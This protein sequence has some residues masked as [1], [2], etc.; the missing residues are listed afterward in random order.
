MADFKTLL[1][2]RDQE[3]HEEV[4]DSIQATLEYLVRRERNPGENPQE[5][6]RPRRH[7]KKE[8]TAENIREIRNQIG[9][10]NLYGQYS[11]TEAVDKANFHNMAMQPILINTQANTTNTGYYLKDFWK[12]EPREVERSIH[13]FYCR[14]AG[15]AENDGEFKQ[16][17]K[18][19]SLVQ[20]SSP[21]I[22]LNIVRLLENRNDSSAEL[23]I[24][25]LENENDA[26][27]IPPRV[28][29]TDRN[30]PIIWVPTKGAR[31]L[32]SMEEMNMLS[33]S[34]ALDDMISVLTN[35][36][37]IINQY[38]YDKQRIMPVL[39]NIIL[40]SKLNV[41]LTDIREPTTRIEEIIARII[42]QIK[43][44]TTKEKATNKLATYKMG[45]RDS[46][47]TT[48]GNLATLFIQA[49]ELNPETSYNPTSENFSDLLYQFIAESM[50]TLT[51]G[52]VK[53]EIAQRLANR[54]GVKKSQWPD[55]DYL[56]RVVDQHYRET[57]TYP[58][59]F[60]CLNSKH[61]PVSFNNHNNYQ[62]QRKTSELEGGIFEK[63]LTENNASTS[64]L[65][66]TE[67]PELESSYNNWASNITN[68]P[69]LRYDQENNQET[70]DTPE[71]VL[72]SE[73]SPL[74]LQNANEES[75]VTFRTN[76]G[77]CTNTRAQTRAR[78]NLFGTPSSGATPV[79]PQDFSQALT[80]ALQGIE[81]NSTP[82]E[83][84][85]Q[86][87]TDNGGR[88]LNLLSVNPRKV[89]IDLAAMCKKDYPTCLKNKEAIKQAIKTGLTKTAQLQELDIP[90]YSSMDDDDIMDLAVLLS[91]QL[92]GK[93]I[94][95]FLINFHKKIPFIIRDKPIDRDGDCQIGKQLAEALYNCLKD[96]N[97]KS[98]YH[99]GYLILTLPV[100]EVAFG[101]LTKA[102][103]SCFGH[104][105]KA[106][107]ISLG[108]HQ[109][110]QPNLQRLVLGDPNII[111]QNRE[112]R[113][114]RM[115]TERNPYRERSATPDRNFRRT[116]RDYEQ[117]KADADQMRELNKIYQRSRSQEQNYPKGNYTP[118]NYRRDRS[119]SP[120][121]RGR[122]ASNDR[123]RVPR[124]SDMDNPI[125]LCQEMN[126]PGTEKAH[127]ECLKCGKKHKTHS[128]Y[129]YYNYNKDPCPNCKELYH[130]VRQCRVVKNYRE[131]I[132]PENVQS[133]AYTPN[134][135]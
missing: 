52:T 62:P 33:P 31:K 7:N 4:I 26:S 130:D 1:K 23:Y 57:N 90:E 86:D 32:N 43:I 66:H 98:I 38:R 118:S 71:A 41:P 15:I 54:S 135:K 21:T 2:R 111:Q 103:K 113:Q 87:D 39:S 95:Q 100:F 45:P 50:K 78:R 93:S 22:T 48:I 30:V 18:N 81:N 17:C 6:P 24:N 65:N 11:L 59:R 34:P 122:S 28:E 102:W 55:L 119:K 70:Y 49:R 123:N 16:R 105:Q 29:G 75:Q 125:Y 76:S 88:A 74:Q 99:Y 69:T 25:P 132:H 106:T 77:P 94:A 112:A 40:R 44:L 27:N 82:R 127:T 114:S 107:T 89:N 37:G 131:K 51:L 97:I 47:E 126:C 104:E 58:D 20:F 72:T 134:R 110:V 83:D 53:Q 109:T 13:S 60:L 80:V 101:R 8:K 85:D 73:V 133:G 120:G 92:N 14:E 129:T 19:P 56:A 12:Y 108:S 36:T 91:P 128:C 84:E 35:L 5:I 116:D 124:G 68:A 115:A 79:T 46:L 64:W 61:K 3:E 96:E 42:K 9:P 117:S 67:E 121:Y 63:Y 10:Y